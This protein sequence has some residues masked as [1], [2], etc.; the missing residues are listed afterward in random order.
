MII[1]QI[2]QEACGC[3]RDEPPANN[4]DLGVYNSNYSSQSFKYKAPLV[5]KTEDVANWKSFVKNTKK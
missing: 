4:A 1:I 3:L 2:H 5:G